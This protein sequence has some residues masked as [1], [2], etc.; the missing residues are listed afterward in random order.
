ME[1]KSSTALVT[2]GGHRVG[3]AIVLALAEAGM[4][5]ALHFHSS[6]EE[7]E[8]TASEARELGAEVVLV[9]GDLSKPEA[10]EEVVSD[11]SAAGPVHVLINSAA[12]FGEGGLRDLDVE[13]F[14]RSLALNLMAPVLLMRAFARSLPDDEQGA[15]INITDWKV[16][17][18]YMSPPRFAYT[19]SKGALITATRVAAIELAPS[20]RVNAV[21]LG[22]ILPPPDEGPEYAEKLG[23]RL[24]LKRVGGTGPVTEA[25]LM[26]A[27][28]D[29]VTGE[30]IRIDGGAH[31]A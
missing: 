10:A 12:G 8:A 24:P 28:N 29:F 2:G 15:I 22:V 11:A 26:L 17:R 6:S 13:K 4:N 3:K 16:D 23:S 27:R 1:L 7:A 25:V 19:V 9:K 18:P 5:I 31:L 20:I 21:A 14:E 30:V